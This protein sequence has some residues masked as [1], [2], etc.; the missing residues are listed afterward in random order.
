MTSQNKQITE[1]AQIRFNHETKR[2]EWFFK[3]GGSYDVKML[4]QRS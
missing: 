1:N 4:T 2:I 3:N